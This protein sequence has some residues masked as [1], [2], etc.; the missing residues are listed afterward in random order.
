MAVFVRMLFFVGLMIM[1]FAPGGDGTMATVLAVSFIPTY[2]LYCI[3]QGCAL[4]NTDTQ[5]LFLRPGTHCII[6][7]RRGCYMDRLYCR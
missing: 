5:L 3:F 4:F 2:H 7:I 1:R 6:W